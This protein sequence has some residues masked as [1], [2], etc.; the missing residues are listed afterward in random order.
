ML[1]VESPIMHAARC[2]AIHS[3][4]GSMFHAYVYVTPIDAS[5]TEMLRSCLRLVQEKAFVMLDVRGCRNKQIV[6]KMWLGL[7]R[8]LTRRRC[9]S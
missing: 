9:V 8:T 2:V 4:Y 6:H 3:G 7:A 1:S 5:Q